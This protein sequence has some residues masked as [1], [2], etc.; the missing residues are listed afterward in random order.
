[1]KFHGR[2]T[3]GVISPL[4]ANLY[5]HWFD[6]VFHRK[7][8]PAERINAKLVRYADDW[9]PR[10]SVNN[11]SGFIEDEGRSLGIDLQGLV[12]NRLGTNDSQWGLREASKEKA[13]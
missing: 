5:L 12:S 10:R 13:A 4:L 7:D 6:V 2:L 3:G 1:M 9:A 11:A 8:G